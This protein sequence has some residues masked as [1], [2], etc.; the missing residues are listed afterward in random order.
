MFI[1]FSGQQKQQLLNTIAK[2]LFSVTVEDY[3]FCSFIKDSGI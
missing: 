2:M 3:L 1:A